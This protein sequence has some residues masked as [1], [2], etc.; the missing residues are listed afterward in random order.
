MIESYPIV[1]VN[2]RNWKNS[3]INSPDSSIITSIENI[4]IANMDDKHLWNLHNIVVPATKDL[5]DLNIN[6]QIPTT[7]LRADQLTSF[8]CLTKTPN[9]NESCNNWLSICDYFLNQNGINLDVTFPTSQQKEEG[10][11]LASQN[12]QTHQSKIYEAK[13][14]LSPQGSLD[15]QVFNQAQQPMGALF[16]NTTPGS[17]NTRYNV[18]GQEFRGLNGP[19]AGGIPAIDTLAILALSNQQKQYLAENKRKFPLIFSITD[20]VSAD[21]SL[22]WLTQQLGSPTASLYTK[23]LFQSRWTKVTN[24]LAATTQ[25]L[26]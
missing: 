4:F 11:Q 10:Y 19:G 14:V 18:L 13:A 26:R 9:T 22:D 5:E 25:D 21:K 3:I 20:N 15:P 16:Q 12:L 7:T 8:L 2:P 23:E 24:N 1:D 6:I 17:L